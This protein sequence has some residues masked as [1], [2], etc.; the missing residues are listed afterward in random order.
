[1]PARY[2][3]PVHTD[4]GDGSAAVIAYQAPN[5]TDGMLVEERF[6]GQPQ[7]RNWLERL[8]LALLDRTLLDLSER[9]ARLSLRERLDREDAAR[10]VLAPGENYPLSFS[11]VCATLKFDPGYIRR[12]LIARA[13]WAFPHE[14]GAGL[15]PAKAQRR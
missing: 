14:A 4:I 10:W 12:G 6:Y 2:H 7:T 11:V 1:M 3:K 8:S 15:S 9:A 5:A 13:P